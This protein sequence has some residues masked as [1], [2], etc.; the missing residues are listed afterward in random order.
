VADRRGVAEMRGGGPA[1]RSRGESALAEQARDEAGCS[2]G[3][4]GPWAIRRRHASWGGRG[5]VHLSDGC[6]DRTGCSYGAPQCLRFAAPHARL[7]GGF[8]R[9]RVN[10]RCMRRHPTV[11]NR[12]KPG[13]FA[14]IRA[15]KEF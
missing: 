3:W 14:E 12:M 13:D 4:I 10:D 9:I 6:C 11:R 15:K 2:I 1:V 5:I 8:S 7:T